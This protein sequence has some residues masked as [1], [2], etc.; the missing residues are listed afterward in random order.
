MISA[1]SILLVIAF[2][3]LSILIVTK[4]FG[5]TVADVF[6]RYGKAL[7]DL[8]AEYG[9][10][11]NDNLLEQYM[12]A[13]K[14]PIVVCLD[15]LLE[16]IE[17]VGQKKS[18]TPQE[19]ESIIRK[20]AEL[21]SYVAFIKMI[22][23]HLHE[24]TQSA[25]LSIDAT[26]SLLNSM[27]ETIQDRDSVAAKNL[28]DHAAQLQIIRLQHVQAHPINSLLGAVAILAKIECLNGGDN[29]AT[30]NSISTLI[31]KFTL[32]FRPEIDSKMLAKQLVSFVRTTRT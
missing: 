5:P 6:G 27:A 32:V 12:I 2:V 17:T 15:S 7:G 24:V 30:L 29:T 19:L 21:E 9:N 26:E 10:S 13:I 8:K 28:Q 16:S 20:I 31:D 23:R 14:S 11:T 18:V 4:L 1:A 3:S 25:Q 22:R